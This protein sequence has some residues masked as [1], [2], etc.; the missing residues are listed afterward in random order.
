MV[1][2]HNVGFSPDSM[3]YL[4]MAENFSTGNGFVNTEGAVI[5]HWPP[6]YSIAIALTAKVTGLRIIDSGI[7]LQPFL[8]FTAIVI[9]LFI[10]KRLRLNSYLIHYSGLLLILSPL[11]GNFAWYLSEGLFY[12]FLLSGFYFLLEWLENKKKRYLIISGVLCGLLFLTRYAG[13]GFIGGYLLIVSI[14]NRTTLFRKITDLIALL[15]P[16]ILTVIPWFIYIYTF[17]ENPA[18]RHFDIHIISTTKLLNLLKTFGF[19][20]LGSML[21]RICFAVLM[22][23]Y[24]LFFSKRGRSFRELIKNFYKRF[25]ATFLMIFLLCSVYIGFLIISISFYDSWTPLDNRT[26]SPVFMFIFILVLLFL[27]FLHEQNFTFVLIITC[28]FLLLS[29]SSSTIP[30]HKIHFL[31]GKGYTKEKWSQSETL[32]GWENANRVVPVYTNAAE[33]GYLH[34]GKKFKVL[35]LKSSEA[36]IHNIFKMVKN[37]NA[38]IMF[39]NNID[40]KNYLIGPQR[41]LK[42]TA[43]LKVEVFEDGF[44]IKATSE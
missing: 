25:S 38:E 5:D 15:L 18:V 13:I 31:R 23:L 21:A 3:S 29:F 7:V 24:F 35:P 40:W 30:S 28:C 19:W 27:Q 8:L 20:F 11:I 36:E 4:E 41:L 39:L 6:L 1:K 33:L 44:I 14:F 10:L 9:F 26:L 37:G 43:G 32:I 34:L 22:V 12:L 2:P 17:K 16:L 42:D